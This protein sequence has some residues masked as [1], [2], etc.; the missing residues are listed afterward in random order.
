MSDVQAGRHR[1]LETRGRAPSIHT[2]AEVP[3]ITSCARANAHVL[4]QYALLTYVVL[5]INGCGYL[6]E[7]EYSGM[8]TRLF[9]GAVYLTY[10][11]VF[12]LPPTV[13][14]LV[15]NRILFAGLLRRWFERIPA[16]R[17]TIVYGCAVLLFTLLQ[18]AAFADRFVYHLYGFHLNGFVWNL[19]FTRGGMESLGG[20]TSTTLSFML[21]I[22]GF[23]VVQT[24]LLILLLTVQRI[25]TLMGPFCR[26]RAL[27]VGFAFVAGAGMFERLTYGISNFR[28]YTPVLLASNAFP[29]YMPITF[30]SLAQKM[31]FKVSREPSMRVNVDAT[32]L[33]YPLQP[34]RRQPV[35]VRY[36]IVWLVSESLRQDMVDPEVMPRTW[37]FAHQSSWFR[38]HYSGGN[39]TRMGMFSMFYGLYGS[40]WFPF[41]AQKRGPVL[42]DVLIDAGYQMKLF[43]SAKFTYPEFNQ[44]IFARLSADQ[45]HEGESQPKWRRDRENVAN[46]LDFIEHRDRAAPFM[47]FMFFDCPHANYYFPQETVIRRPY[48]EDLNYATMDLHKDIGLIKNRYINAGNHLATQIDRILK[49][50]EEQQLLNST[51]VL[52]TGDH[53]EEFMEKGRW[54]HNS[55]FTEEQT[56]PPLVIWVPGRAPRE[57]TRMT[58]HLDIPATLMPLL[59]VTN[60]PRDYSLGYDLF[61]DVVRDFVVISDWSNIA[62]VDQ[63]FKA[64]FPMRSYGFARQKITT[65]DDG[66]VKDRAEFYTANK[67][68]IVD[69]MKQLT[70]FSR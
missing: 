31:G 19:V 26:G 9:A 58:S 27:I 16:F 11:F 65:R 33:Q 54:G 21:I 51:I 22:L 61:G 47:T 23:L 40:Y 25:R 17:S 36:N 56:R 68:R 7:I 2:S 3:L 67:A 8:I 6:R 4:W 62:Y 32:R 28:G 50:L 15:L 38:Q 52:I 53:G 70:V 46:L 41:L 55:E 5:L 49:Y 39:G 18:I 13:I 45:L 29:L 42:M 14:L 57:V 64:V 34:I 35:P 24:A 48:A 12:L 37:A 44:T 43:T 69:L 20:G 59:G 63:R 60:P 1:L 66:P 30:N 10:F